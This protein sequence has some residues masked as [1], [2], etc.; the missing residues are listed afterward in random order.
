MNSSSSILYTYTH[1]H[2]QTYFFTVSSVVKNLPSMRR[3][4]RHRFD[5]WVMKIHWRRKWQPTPAFSPGK[6]HGQRSLV[7]YSPCGHKESETTEQLNS[8]NSVLYTHTH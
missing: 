6:S 3:N 7:G 2:S 5:S 4:R 8:S 1:T